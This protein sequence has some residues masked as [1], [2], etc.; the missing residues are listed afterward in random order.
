MINP[1]SNSTEKNNQSST[2]VKTSKKKPRLILPQIFA[3]MPNRDTLGGTSYL[4][5]HP[6]GN[7][8]IDSPPWQENTYEFVKEHQGV[9]YLF[10]T[11]RN[12]I[13]KQ[14]KDIY[15]EFNCQ[16]IIQEQE[17][18]LLPNQDLISFRDEYQLNSDCKL[19]WTAGYSP[20]SA[21]LYSQQNQGVLFSGRH[22]LPIKDS[23]ISPLKLRKTF[24]WQRQ[25]NNVKRLAELFSVSNLNYICPGSNTGY[26]RQKGYIDNAYTKLV[27]SIEENKW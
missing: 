21:C 9:K 4:M 7:I 26:L 14:V 17:A 18:Y 10:F 19:I 22:L 13:S 15:N 12:G 6:Q 2:D 20:G 3:F 27:N 11:Q 1:N 16:L 5:I 24:H 8:L 23:K 25:V